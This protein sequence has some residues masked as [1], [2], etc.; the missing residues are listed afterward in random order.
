MKFP[1]FSRPRLSSTESPRPFRGVWGNAPQK[2]FKIRIYNLAENEFQTT[3]FPDFS[4]TFGILF[5]QIPWLSEVSFKFPD[6]SRFSKS[7]ATLYILQAKYS[8]C[9]IMHIFMDSLP[10]AIKFTHD[11]RQSLHG[12]KSYSSDLHHPVYSQGRRY[13]NIQI[14]VIVWF[15]NGQSWLRRYGLFGMMNQGARLPVSQKQMHRATNGHPALPLW[16][17]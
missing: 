10:K 2:I 7:A 4:L 12:H 5:R 13:W 9:L 15:K 1:D 11:A 3:K 8:F 16:L 17:T 14:G 6:F